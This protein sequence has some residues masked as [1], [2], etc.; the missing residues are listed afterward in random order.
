MN[1]PSSESSVRSGQQSWTCQE[2]K[3]VVI[4]S[5]SVLTEEKRRA[6]S[7]W[8]AES[9]VSAC[10]RQCKQ[11]GWSQWLGVCLLAELEIS[12]GLLDIYEIRVDSIVCLTCKSS[13]SFQLFSFW[14]FIVLFLRTFA[15]S[16]FNFFPLSFLTFIFS[17]IFLYMHI[18]CLPVL[19]VS[20]SLFICFLLPSYLHYFLL[21]F[22]IFPPSSLPLFCFFI[23][24]LRHFPPD[25]FFLSLILSFITYVSV[26]LL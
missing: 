17:S 9:S 3:F 25:S 1:N 16:L 6:S 18:L 4:R 5:F 14:V 24:L 23:Y 22:H 7:S 10:V 13:F 2:H 19:S 26:F 8:P 15:P 12:V 11:Y 21:S 20:F